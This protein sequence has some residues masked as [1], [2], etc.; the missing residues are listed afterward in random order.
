[1][2][3]MPHPRQSRGHFPV[4]VPAGR[5][6]RTLPLEPSAHEGDLGAERT[7]GV[8]D[9]EEKEELQSVENQVDTRLLCTT[10]PTRKGL[11]KA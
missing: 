11:G 10:P 3:P 6:L 4:K 8:D 1:M 2:S 7:N 5:V 9:M